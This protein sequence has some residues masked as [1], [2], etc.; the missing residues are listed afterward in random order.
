MWVNYN[1]ICTTHFPGNG[2]KQSTSKNGDVPDGAL[3]II[4]LLTIIQVLIHFVASFTH[5]NPL[6][7]TNPITVVSP[8]TILRMIQAFHCWK[9]TMGTAGVVHGQ[10]ES[11]SKQ[12]R[13]ISNVEIWKFLPW[14]MEIW[15][16][17]F[18]CVHFF[19]WLYPGIFTIYHGHPWIMSK[20]GMFQGI[21]VT[22]RLYFSHI[23]S[24][25]VCF[26]F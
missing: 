21:W 6:S 22:I 4:V 2:F 24:I 12:N 19:I 20:H 9:F 11:G 25:A 15:L 16:V 23:F 13:Q 17:F 18:K 8:H 7:G 26:N 14:K 1:V 3:I 5:M 10:I